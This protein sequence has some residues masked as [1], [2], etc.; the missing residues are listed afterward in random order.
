MHTDYSTVQHIGEKDKAMDT[1]FTQP[2]GDNRVVKV[3]RMN[4]KFYSAM[5]N[6]N[7]GRITKKGRIAGDVESGF[8]YINDMQG[9]ST[10]ED[11]LKEYGLDS[12]I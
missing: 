7:T 6:P 11:A 12:P 2:L 9:H 4:G 8:R 10:L 3:V 5:L 1:V